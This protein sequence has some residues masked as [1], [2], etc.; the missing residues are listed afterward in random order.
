M[1]LPILLALSCAK[2]QMINRTSYPWNENDQWNVE[3]AKQK[4][5][6]IYKNSPCLTK[7]IKSGKQDYKAICGKEKNA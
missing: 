6:K 4:C 7:F 3:Q 1:I 2:P 5:P